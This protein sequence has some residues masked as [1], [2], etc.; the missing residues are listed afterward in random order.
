[1]CRRIRMRCTGCKSEFQIHEIAEDL[2]YETEKILE[3]YTSI[4]Y[5]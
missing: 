5:D 2:D 4:I 3:Q 1:M